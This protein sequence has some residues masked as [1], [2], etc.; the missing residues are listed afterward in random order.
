[1]LILRLLPFFLAGPLG[2]VI[3]DRF[4]RKWIMVLTDGV[5]VLFVLGM[6]AAPLIQ[7]PLALIYVLTAL[8]VVASA[9]FEPARGAALPQLVPPRHL[10]AANAL[11]AM[12]WSVM[13]AL[14]AALGGVVA[15]L[16]GW[17]TRARSSTR[18][19]TWSRP[20]SSRASCCRAARASKKR[21]TG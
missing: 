11:G 21:W 3:A 18:A 7:A 6:I 8:Q 15:D 14:G 5:R 17:R 4:S 13:F 9:F 10:A 1:M 19:P 20:G 2:G 16:F 12:A